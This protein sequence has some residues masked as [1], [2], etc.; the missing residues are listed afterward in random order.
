MQIHWKKDYSV[1][2]E[3]LDKQH[4]RLISL[5]NKLFLLYK[6][7]K[8]DSVDVN[9]IF[10][11]LTDYADEHFS[12]E[13]YYFKLYGYEKEKQHIELHNNYRKKVEELKKSHEDNNSS[14]TLFAISNF[15]QDWWIWHI[16]HADKDYTDYFHANGLK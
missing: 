8:F 10:K 14:E 15:L 3:E 12:T 1:G 6:D 2:V 5:I 16:N 4:Q 11:D 13:E 7:N 9:R